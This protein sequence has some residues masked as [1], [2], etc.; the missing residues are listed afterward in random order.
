LDVKLSWSEGVEQQVTS[1]GRAN[2]F[3]KLEIV[4]ST[5]TIIKIKCQEILGDKW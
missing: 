5:A 3:K 1:I 2:Q 4:N